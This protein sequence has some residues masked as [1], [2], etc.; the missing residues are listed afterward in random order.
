MPVLSVVLFEL[1]V[2]LV[3]VFATTTGTERIVYCEGVR[4]GSRC[5]RTVHLFIVA[6]LPVPCVFR[7]R[8]VGS[9]CYD[10]PHPASLILFSSSCGF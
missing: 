10:V 6:S 1:C 4:W 8:T 5:R 7:G 3:R 9:S 2:T